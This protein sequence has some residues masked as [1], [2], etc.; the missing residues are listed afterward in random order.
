MARITALTVDVSQIQALGDKIGLLTG[1]ELGAA[2]VKALNETLDSAYALSRTRMREGINLTDAYLRRKFTMERATAQVPKAVLTATG[3]QT[4]LSEYSPA[5]QVKPVNWSNARIRAA[6]HKF[7]KWPGWT[8]RKGNSR[9]NIAV[10]DKSDG[11]TVGVTVGGRSAFMHAFSIAGKTDGS[12]N[13][14][15][16]TRKPGTKKTRALLGPA[17]YQLFAYQLKGTLLGETEDLLAENLTEQAS[18]ALQKALGS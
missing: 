4:L 7:G 13:L 2:N 14:I 1:E 8:E 10:D 5:Q 11:Q 3:T 12:G 17:A 18:A 6:G 16:F 9:L 15:M